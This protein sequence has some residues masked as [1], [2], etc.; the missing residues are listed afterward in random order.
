MDTVR[1]I[2]IVIGVFIVI[3]T[4]IALAIDLPHNSSSND[5]PEPPGFKPPGPETPGSKPPGPETPG[6]KP[7]GPETPGSKPP[8][9]ETPGSKPPGPE[10]PGPETRGPKPSQGTCLNLGDKIPSD[11]SAFPSKPCC[12][13][14][15]PSQSSTW[16]AK[17]FDCDVE[18]ACNKYNSGVECAKHSNK[19]TIA[20]FSAPP[21]NDLYICVDKKY[22][23][24]IGFPYF[25]PNLEYGPA[26]KCSDK[27]SNSLFS[28]HSDNPEWLAQSMDNGILGCGDSRT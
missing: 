28:C 7:P 18:D 21:D 4:V 27:L 16:C 3:G 14:L 24:G 13:G 10:T 25:N 5:R 8:G 17:E 6:S 1:I 12:S 2:S 22:T 9:P 23:A 19:C 15:F 26:Q 20:S 11:K